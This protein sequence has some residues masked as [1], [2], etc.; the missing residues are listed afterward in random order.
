M[1]PWWQILQ[2]ATMSYQRCKYHHILQK[3]YEIETCV[4][5]QLARYQ[6]QP[7]IV[8]APNTSRMRKSYMCAPSSNGNDVQGH[9]TGT[10]QG[11]ALVAD[12][13]PIPLLLAVFLLI[14]HAYLIRLSMFYSCSS[15]T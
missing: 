4:A 8:G 9:C 5:L 12:V 3:K 13:Q 14:S 7:T 6:L 10:P 15:I 11:S 2:S 1:P